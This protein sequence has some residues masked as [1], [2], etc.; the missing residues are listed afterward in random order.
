MSALIEHRGVVSAIEG[1]EAVVL[2]AT[3]GCSSCGHGDHCGISK[4]GGGQRTAEFRVPATPG[5]QV[6]DFVN[7]ALPGKQLS[8]AAI[9]GYLFPALSM[10]LGAAVGATGQGSDAT[11]ALGAMAGFLGALIVV[12]M[13]LSLT[14]AFKPQPRLQTVSISSQIIHQEFPNVRRSH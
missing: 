13:A 7:L 4:V 10:L 11:V 2:I 12:R 14:P 1:R 3:A 9:L 6:G 5:L 8:L